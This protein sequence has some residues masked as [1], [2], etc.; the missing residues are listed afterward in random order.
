MAL[1]LTSTSLADSRGAA[2]FATIGFGFLAFINA[3]ALVLG[4]VVGHVG[5]TTVEQTCAFIISAS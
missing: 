4:I 1:P 5:F 2:A 3:L